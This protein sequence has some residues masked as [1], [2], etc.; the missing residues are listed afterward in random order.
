M[1]KLKGKGFD[2]AARLNVKRT[3]NGGDVHTG[4][5]ILRTDGRVLR[6]WTGEVATS[7]TIIGK[8]RNMPDN[9]PAM[10]ELLTRVAAKRG[11]EPA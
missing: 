5:Y 2:E 9:K 7:Y 6:R 11:W 3:T 4:I 8:V 10:I 1:A